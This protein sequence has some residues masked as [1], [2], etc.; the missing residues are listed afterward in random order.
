MKKIAVFTTLAIASIGVVFASIDI[1]LKYGQKG[2]EVSELQEFLSDKGY[3]T[4]SPSGFFGLM[5][6][7]AVKDYQVS[8][9]LP[10]T[11]YVGYMTREKINTILNEEVAT[12]IEAEVKETGTTTVTT[13]VD[14]CPNIEGTQNIIPAGMFMDSVKGCFIPEVNTSFVNY[15]PSQTPTQQVQQPIKVSK[16]SLEFNGCFPGSMLGG[17]YSCNAF[18]IIRDDNGVIKSIV[19]VIFTYNDN[20][21]NIVVKDINGGAPLFFSNPGTYTIT[22]EVPSLGLIKSS[23]ITIGE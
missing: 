19:D 17:K 4:S 3:L 10:A 12:S 8:V 1:N 15:S 2:Q 20:G 14:V 23:N 7:K 6:L 5:T 11:G 22:M 21:K 16:K 9:S 18:P 13:N